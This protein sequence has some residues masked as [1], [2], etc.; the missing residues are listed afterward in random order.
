M[1]IEKLNHVGQGLE[2]LTSVFSE[3]ENLKIF[4][5]AFLKQLEEIEES[6]IHLSK[7][8]DL[9][10]ITGVWLD[11][12]GY[13]IGRP[14]GGMV[15]EEY[16][17]ALQLKISINKSDGTPPAVSEIVKTYTESDKVRISEGIL[18]FGQI[19]FNGE[20]N[21]DKTLWEL[22][23][24]IKPVTANVLLVQDT[25]NKCFFPAWEDA[26]I[27]LELF[28]AVVSEGSSE[29]LELIIGGNSIVNLFLN[30]EGE[31]VQYDP[32][33]VGRQFLEWEDLDLF[34]FFDGENEF[35]IEVQIDSNTADTLF[36]EGVNSAIL[37]ETLLP[38]EIN[39]TSYINPLG[40]TE[41][42]IWFDG[43]V[44]GS[45]YVNLDENNLEKFKVTGVPLNG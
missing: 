44:T 31:E 45:L 40:G 21:A 1:T 32:D 2:R 33:T 5:S 39:S 29:T 26:Q 43:I 15:D 38:W 7:Q 30:I 42:F 6:L 12:I 16:R 19:I 23:Q 36:F 9:T 37:N 25:E 34:T 3:S 22:I 14:R 27:G 24:D 28:N 35:Q 20:K 17:Q 41:D 18:S 13:I 8:K 10:T 4:L 11:Y